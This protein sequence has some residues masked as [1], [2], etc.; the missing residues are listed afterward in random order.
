MSDS[1][2]DDD[3]RTTDFGNRVWAEPQPGPSRSTV[4]RQGYCGCCKVLYSNLDQ[5]LSSLRH[6]DSVRAS[7]SESSNLSTS[8][9]GTLTL[10]ERFLQDVQQYHPHRYSDPR[11]SHTDLPL[12]S[13]PPLPKVEDEEILCPADEGGSLGSYSSHD[14]SCQSDNYKDSG[15]H[16]Q[17]GKVQ[18]RLSL[19]VKQQEVTAADRHG[20][21]RRRAPP[22]EPVAPPSQYP[23][24]P[25]VHRKAHRKT[26][27]RKTSD[28]SSSPGPK[29]CPLNLQPSTGLGA[30]EGPA[31]RL[32]PVTESRP[33]LSWQRKRKETH[34]EAFSSGSS[35]LLQQTIEEVIQVCCYGISSTNYQQEEPES[36]HLSL[37]SSM[38]SH[39]EEWDL[40]VQDGAATSTPVQ[41][42]LMEK[43]DVS[44]LM[45]VQVQLEDRMY[46]QQL[47]SALL[48]LEGGTKQDEGFWTLPIEE[49]LPAPENI[50]ESFRGKSWVQIE[51]E[52][53]EKVDKLVQQFRQGRFICYF[54]TESLARYGRRSQSTKKP[55]ENVR[56]KVLSLLEHDSDDITYVK[57]RRP[58]RTA[59]RCQVVK[60]SHSTQT[61]PL[62]I[63][64][65]HPPAPK[66]PPT[67]TTTDKNAAERTPNT[68]LW[69][70]LPPCYSSIVTPVQPRTSLVYLLCSSQDSTPAPAG[71]S[72]RN[73]RRR[74]S[75]N[76][77]TLKYKRLPVQVYEPGTNRI[78]K[79]F[80]K[81]SAP[82]VPAHPCVRQLFRSLSPDLNSDRPPGQLTSEGSF[83]QS[84]L[85]RESDQ[86]VI[87]RRRRGTA[88]A[89]APPL[90][91]R[92]EQC[93]DRQERTNP[94]PS[95]SRFRL[96][97]LPL[98]PRREGLRPACPGRRHPTPISHAPFGSHRGKGQRGRAY[99]RRGR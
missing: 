86:T 6:L 14:A 37:P 33:W 57:R 47:D 29:R 36:I 78:L 84:A 74:R 70:R 76:W 41:T 48:S 22:P 7:S 46:S 72:R 4:S 10:L 75:P 56:V 51:K 17:S 60:V 67:T 69:R 95:K 42:G 85:R 73:R 30:G 79:K 19:S 77:Q 50:P 96:Q 87:V 21:S 64:A 91:S 13:A 24:P 27:R 89:L 1:S 54:D 26:N 66:V 38:A 83:L 59:S 43:Q 65:V 2:D 5:H 32:P 3:P 82:S 90:G 98:T 68:Q 35:D 12:V 8:H 88:Q 55:G 23:A 9:R 99:K 53:E 58:F 92:A 45:D 25:S 11:P 39:S 61:T 63:P 97:S 49:V 44:R 71:G 18:E 94:P 40:G 34:K 20:Q 15:R 16:S 80:P 28:S 93:K 62:I 52:D 81:S 31:Q